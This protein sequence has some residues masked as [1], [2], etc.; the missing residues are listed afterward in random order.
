MSSLFIII[1][2]RP[3]SPT[4]LIL[5]AKK[6]HFRSLLVRPIWECG[7]AIFGRKSARKK[8]KLLPGHTLFAKKVHFR[9]LLVR[10]IWECDF[11]IFGRKSDEK[12]V[13]TCHIL[14]TG[15]ELNLLFM[16]FYSLT[17]QKCH[18]NSRFHLS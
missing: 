18:P 15:S 3:N 8:R 7:F 2:D 6:V 5:F 14:V 1:T 11:A 10:P 16:Q 4:T 12:N 13:Q 9:S 17:H